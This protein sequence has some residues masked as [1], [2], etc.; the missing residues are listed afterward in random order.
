MD[1][2]GTSNFERSGIGLDLDA[3]E[4][5]IHTLER[6]FF[7]HRNGKFHEVRFLSGEYTLLP[8]FIDVLIRAN[9]RWGHDVMILYLALYLA[10]DVDTEIFY[11]CE[12]AFRLLDFES[13]TLSV[14]WTFVWEHVSDGSE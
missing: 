9:S 8:A 6:F 5:S 11:D 12:L 13:Q 10:N 4:R 2:S 1:W 7:C 14:L 3:H